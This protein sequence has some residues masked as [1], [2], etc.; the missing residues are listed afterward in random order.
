MVSIEELALGLSRVEKLKLMEVLWG[1]LISQTESVASPIW[2]EEVLKKTEECLARGEEK[3][4]EWKIAKE[5][6][7]GE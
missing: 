3:V 2:H 4:V 7:R 6:L 5:V 1:D